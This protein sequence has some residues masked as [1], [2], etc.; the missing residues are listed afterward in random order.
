MS[1]P[2]E[3]SKIMPLVE[4]AAGTYGT[5]WAFDSFL[6]KPLNNLI[7]E[8][9]TTNYLSLFLSSALSETVVIPL[10]DE[11]MISS[12]EREGKIKKYSA[13]NK[14]YSIWQE[15]IKGNEHILSDMAM[16][17]GSSLI[18]FML[19]QKFMPSL[20][21]MS[22]EVARRRILITL[23]SLISKLIIPAVKEYIKKRKIETPKP[24]I[25]TF[26]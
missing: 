26:N 14:S 12:E 2:T 7:D 22:D 17:G 21:Y 25:K 11:F 20:F 23:S 16:Y 10:F 15:A 13:N 1:I 4:T 5:Q 3:E 8:R 19:I 9:T 18:I 6:S 24:E